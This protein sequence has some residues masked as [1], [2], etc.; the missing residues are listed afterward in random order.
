MNTAIVSSLFGG[1][2]EIDTDNAEEWAVSW[3]WKRIGLKEVT[4]EMEAP[5]RNRHNLDTRRLQVT[6]FQG[7]EDFYGQ[8]HPCPA[9]WELAV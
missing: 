3:K 1:I 5:G 7:M 8:K 9:N 2:K 6:R 4:E